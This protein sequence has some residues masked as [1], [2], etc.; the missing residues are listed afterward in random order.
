[1]GIS[2]VPGSGKTHTLSYLAAQLLVNSQLDVEQEI[3][4]VTLVNSAVDN[5][6]TRIAGFVK[7]YGL[8]ENVGYRVRTLHGL[9]HDIIL[10]R[11]DMAGLSSQF[12]IV[13]D[14]ESDRMIERICEGYIRLTL[15]WLVTCSNL[16][17][18]LPRSAA[19]E[20]VGLSLSP[21]SIKISSAKPR[22]CRLN[23]RTFL[24]S[25]KNIIMAT[26]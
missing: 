22:T 26:H 13:D 16:M 6:T 23:L 19:F 11:P 8:L 18:M 15:N 21:R 7:D 24:R 14:L 5:F 17:S 25:C 20:M 1:M 12:S 10:E 3:L 2:A 4:V 9:A